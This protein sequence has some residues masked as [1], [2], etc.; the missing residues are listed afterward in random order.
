MVAFAVQSVTA[1]QLYKSAFVKSD[2]TEIFVE[3]VCKKTTL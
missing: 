3:N 2:L 1:Y